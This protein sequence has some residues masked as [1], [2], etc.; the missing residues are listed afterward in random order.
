[1]KLYVKK[2]TICS[3][4]FTFFM[5]G[6]FV[7]CWDSLQSPFCNHF[8]QFMIILSPKLNSYPSLAR[9]LSYSHFLVIRL[10]FFFFHSLQDSLFSPETLQD[11]LCNE[12][13]VHDLYNSDNQTDFN[14][15]VSGFTSSSHTWMWDI[16]ANTL[17]ELVLYQ[18]KTFSCYYQS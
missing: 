18:H 17:N 11:V 13:T 16:W 3:L 10:H 15:S 4:Q 7:H 8:F 6:F 1:M 12:E 2:S 9:I 5:G 14:T